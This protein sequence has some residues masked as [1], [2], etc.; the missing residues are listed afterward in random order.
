MAGPEGVERDLL[1][2]ALEMRRFQYLMAFLQYPEHVDKAL[3]FAWNER[4]CPVFHR[5]IEREVHGVDCFAAVYGAKEDIMDSVVKYLDEQWLAARRGGDLRG[6]GFYEL[7]AKFGGKAGRS[8]LI[9]CVRYCFLDDRFDDA[10][11]QA[12][13]ANAPIE[14]HHLT[15][16]FGPDEVEL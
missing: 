8:A 16:D 11:Y 5:T 12:V 1:I 14:A 9:D 3:A 13:E 6:V 15:R 7:E 2:A 10:L 4:I